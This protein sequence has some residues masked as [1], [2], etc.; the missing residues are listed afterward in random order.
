[1]NK[2]LDQMYHD[3]LRGWSNK[4][5]IWQWVAVTI[6]AIGSLH[7]SPL[8]IAAAI[9]NV[10]CVIL[11]AKGRVSNYYWGLVG[12]IC[13]A[14]VAYQQQFYG[15]MMLN[16][17][18]VG[19]QFWGIYEWRKSLQK[20]DPVLQFISGKHRGIGSNPALDPV[21]AETFSNNKILDNEVDIQMTVRKTTPVD[22]P[23]KQL[24]LLGLG[25]VFLAVVFGTLIAALILTFIDDPAPYLD[26]FTLVAS[27]IAMT[28]MVKRYSEQWLLWNAVNIASIY[29]WVVPALYKPGAW[30]MVAMWS[31][32]LLNSLYGTYKW[33]LIKENK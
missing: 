27:L 4:E 14:I 23:V 26:G 7:A 9:T 18:Y 1:M 29:M 31:V 3:H 32:F 21:A 28:L 11:V 20:A 12:V 13:Y 33:Y 5:I 6:V 17:I 15:N 16:I 30:A 24:S 2:I 10:F 25:A 19:F 22:V 8:E